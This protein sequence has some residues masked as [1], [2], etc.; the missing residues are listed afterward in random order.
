[1]NGGWAFIVLP[2][3]ANVNREKKGSDED[4]AQ[5]LSL[6]LIFSDLRFR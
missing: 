1:M 2:K 6:V 5:R 3:F 4:V